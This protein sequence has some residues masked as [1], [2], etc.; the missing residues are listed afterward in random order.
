MYLRFQDI[1]RTNCS[2]IKLESCFA[3]TAFFLEID[4]ETVQYYVVQVVQLN[5]SSNLKYIYCTL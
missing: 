3:L 2:N 5:M 1:T 4:I